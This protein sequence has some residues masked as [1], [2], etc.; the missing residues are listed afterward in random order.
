MFKNSFYLLGSE[1]IARILSLVVMAVLARRIGVAEFGLFSLAS[2]VAFLAGIGMDFGLNFYLVRETARE[3]DRIPEL[4]GNSLLVKFALSIA[5]GL[6][7]WIGF[8]LSGANSTLIIATRNLCLWIAILTLGNSYRMLLRG[9]ERMDLEAWITVADALFKSGLALLAALFADLETVTLAIA[10]SAGLTFFLARR[11]TYHRFIHEPVRLA[12]SRLYPMLA[13]SFSILLSLLLLNAFSS[14]TFFLV[15]RLLPEFTT[16]LYAAADKIYKLLFMLPLVLGQ[17]AYPRLASLPPGPDLEALI[18]RLYTAGSAALAPISAG[19]I[20][21]A[22]EAL[23]FLFGPAFVPAA[24]AL[25][26]LAL[27]AFCLPSVYAGLHSLNARR[28]GAWASLS[29][30][31]AMALLFLLNLVLLPR[32]RMIGAAGAELT[33]MSLLSLAFLLFSARYSASPHLA[34]RLGLRIGLLGLPLALAWLGS[35]AGPWRILFWLSGLA[36]TGLTLHRFEPDLLTSLLAK[37]R[38]IPFPLPSRVGIG[39]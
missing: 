15:G 9:R 11:L 24:P 27:A 16:G 2:A 28:D 30:A 36:A 34:L 21:F 14:T 4:L 33:G 18:R 6:A 17:A 22:P 37:L 29:L 20:L 26:L 25:R 8:R 23:R 3:P 5:L 31:G 19:L 1:T 38:H 32:F 13:A 12:P 7:V 35:D 39:F 10:G